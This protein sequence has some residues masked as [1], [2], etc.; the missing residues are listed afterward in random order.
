MDVAFSSERSIEDELERVSKAEVYTVIIS[1]G[2]MFAYI[3]IALG[4]FRSFSTLLVSKC[5][6]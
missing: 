2:V 4:H 6:N 1:Y 3:A 5:F